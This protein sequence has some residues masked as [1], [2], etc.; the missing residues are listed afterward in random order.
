M[1]PAPVNQV[2][3]TTGDKTLRGVFVE[4][5]GKGRRFGDHT[6]PLAPVALGLFERAADLAEREGRSDYIFP[7]RGEADRYPYISPDSATRAMRRLRRSIGVA[8]ISLHDLRRTMTT[9]MDDELGVDPRVLDAL[10]NHRPQGV[11]GKHNVARLN[12]EFHYII[13]AI[14]SPGSSRHSTIM[15]PRYWASDFS[16]S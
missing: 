4:G 6:V 16:P 11:T 15:P 5:R 3:G 12:D 1:T 10:L 14:N 2:Q 13:Q 7:A 9:V 8:D